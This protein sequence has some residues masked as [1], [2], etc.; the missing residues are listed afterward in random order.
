MKFNAL[1][2][3]ASAG[4]A[5]TYF[6][7]HGVVVKVASELLPQRARFHEHLYPNAKMFQGDITEKKPGQNELYH[8]IL[9]A[10]KNFSDFF[11]VSLFHVNRS[12]FH[13]ILDGASQ[14]L[15]QMR[16]STQPVEHPFLQ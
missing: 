7:K 11:T 12:P 16:M 5:E 13:G 9:L 2:M 6:A 4:V 10:K 3:F 1:S 8:L 14:C 15:L